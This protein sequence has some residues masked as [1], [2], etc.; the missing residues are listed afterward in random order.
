V[1]ITISTRACQGTQFWGSWIQS[2]NHTQFLWD[3]C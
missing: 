3:S 2:T 1:I